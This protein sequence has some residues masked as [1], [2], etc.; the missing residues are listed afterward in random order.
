MRFTDG[1]K[2]VEIVAKTWDEERKVFSHDVTPAIFFD[3]DGNFT[4]EAWKSAFATDITPDS[5]LKVNYVEGLKEDVIVVDDVQALVRYARDWMTVD[6][7]WKKIADLPEEDVEREQTSRYIKAKEFNMQD[8]EKEIDY[9]AMPAIDVPV[10]YGNFATARDNDEVDLCQRSKQLNRDCAEDIQKAINDCRRG[11]SYHYDMDSAVKSVVGT[12]GTERVAA[13]VAG[14][15]QQAAWDGR[16]TPDMKAWAGN[17][18]IPAV[19]VPSMNTH[20]ILLNAFAEG[21]DKTM[22][23]QALE[24]KMHDYGFTQEGIEPVS[25]SD[26]IRKFRDDNQTIYKLF[27]DGTKTE[28]ESVKD[29]YDHVSGG[30]IC[31]YEKNK[32]LMQR[33]IDAGYSVNDMD[34]HETDLYVYVTPQTTKIINEWCKENGYNP[35]WQCPKFTDQITGKQMYDCAFQY[36]P[37]WEK[38]HEA[39]H[40][41]AGQRPSVLKALHEKQ[42]VIAAAGKTTPAPEKGKTDPVL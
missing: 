1:A 41:E 8:M 17:I 2:S 9:K 23:Q 21:L 3:L 35:D 5:P 20:P 13:V 15:I 24:Q 39:V 11:D 4:L 42:E 29:L 36:L 26:A 14:T 18:K 12:Y 32:P 33:L 7:D 40:E 16:Y 30:G 10:Y 38:K 34:H 6:G 22:K 37:A 28:A 25:L 27:P 19:R 31:G